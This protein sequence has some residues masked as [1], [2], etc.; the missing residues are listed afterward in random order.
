MKNEDKHK[1]E[2]NSLTLAKIVCKWYI[3]AI[4]GFAVGI[5]KGN[6]ATAVIGTV[7]GAA[8]SWIFKMCLLSKK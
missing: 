7:V 6:L 5:S 1:N 3:G 4:V 2:E 8:V